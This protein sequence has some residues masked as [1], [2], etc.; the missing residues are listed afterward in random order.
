MFAL[1][2][3][4]Q[5]IEL[6]TS[7][8]NPWTPDSVSTF[9]QCPTSV[10]HSIARHCGV[11]PSPQCPTQH[12][13]LLRSKAHNQMVW[14]RYDYEN[15]QTVDSCWTQNG[16]ILYPFTQCTALYTP[17]SL[18]KPD[19]HARQDGRQSYSIRQS[20]TVKLGS[21]NDSHNC[22][23]KADGGIQC[24]LWRRTSII[25]YTTLNTMQYMNTQYASTTLLGSHT[26]S[27][28][29]IFADL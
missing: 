5:R 28:H 17:S 16:G 9:P 21:H 23:C 10:R 19:S 25:L 1:I 27:S 12:A 18:W 6:W 22:F 3:S 14:N 4:C 8:R 29:V 11:E 15:H 20:A 7:C 13:D 26:R 24:L 2:R